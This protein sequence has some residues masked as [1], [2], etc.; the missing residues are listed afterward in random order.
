MVPHSQ[1]N[2]A[3]SPTQL[4]EILESKNK[5]FSLEL[6][7][8]ATRDF[9]HLLGKGAFGYVYQEKLKDA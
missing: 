8:E 9:S 2:I 4:N 6:L 5:A 7:R 3:L 1:Q